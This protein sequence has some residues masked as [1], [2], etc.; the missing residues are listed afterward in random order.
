MC[1]SIHARIYTCAFACACV[2]TRIYLYLRI[3]RHMH[4]HAYVNAATSVC[5]YTYAHMSH[6][7]SQGKGQVVSNTAS[8]LQLGR[9][10]LKDTY[11]LIIRSCNSNCLNLKI[12]GA[13]FALLKCF[14]VPMHQCTKKA[15]I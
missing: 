15:Q 8:E 11:A 2:H 4:T 3:F 13:N 14:A 1:T 7:E 12:D 9:G 6:G 10:V 5:T